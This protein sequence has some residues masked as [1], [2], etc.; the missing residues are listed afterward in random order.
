MPKSKRDKTGLG[1]AKRHDPLDVQ[2]NNDNDRKF[3]KTRK[4][5]RAKGNE[6]EGEAANDVVPGDMSRKILSFARE[7]LEE[8]RE[9][10]KKQ[11]SKKEKEVQ[12]SDDE[13]DDLNDDQDGEY[14]IEYL[15]EDEYETMEVHEE[16]ER[17][18]EAFM[19]KKKP[20]RRS[21]ADIIM[22]K[23]REKEE[24]AA[25]QAEA[26]EKTPGSGAVTE[27]ARPKMNPQ[28][29][30]VYQSIGKLLSRYRAGKIPK[31]FKIIPVLRNWEEVLYYT[32]PDMWSSQ[33]M[34]AAT[35]L[36]ASNLNPQ[37]A[38]RFYAL[39]LLPAV[40]D[41]IAE[42]KKL[43]YHL[44][45]SLK[46]AV[47]RP[48]A[49]FKGI[50]LPLC[51]S[52]DCTLR[53]AAII[54]SVLSKVSIPMMHSAAA[55]LKMSSMSYSGATS[56]FLRVLL[57]KKYS[58]PYKVVDTL[59][60]HFLVFRKETRILPVLW[61]QALLV[62]VQRYKTLLTDEQKE[63]LKP[64]LREHFHHHITPEIRRELYSAVSRD[65][66]KRH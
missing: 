61:H 21:L 19:N 36:F 1:K 45:M 30:E 18:L 11:A 27:T 47:Y 8:E 65:P 37:M 6:D 60:R 9:A 48:A 41:D 4:V 26:A 43:N 10:R 13:D 56:L 62:F 38:Q 17:A 32:N 49:F 55:M 39:V 28:L 24:R 15:N 7:Q 34:A 22:E 2:L 64:L 57:D 25:R 42:N 31:A 29:V 3:A 33:A 16:D 23:I 44:Y 14:E 35:R 63:S 58:L 20:E 5:R 53:E 59:V 51:E 52:G 12:Q 66:K 40:R 50:L 46:K 54:G